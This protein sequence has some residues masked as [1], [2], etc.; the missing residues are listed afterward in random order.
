MSSETSGSSERR[1]T[2]WLG[3]ATLALIT[4]VGAIAQK[5][6]GANAAVAACVYGGGTLVMAWVTAKTT[7]YPRWAWF[8][9][10]AVLVAAIVVAAMRL[11]EPAQVKSWTSTAWM[12]PWLFL[13]SALSPAPATGR[14]SP[15]AAWS[16]PLLVGTSVAFSSILLAAWWMTR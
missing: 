8:A 9:A 3:C 13:V 6:T 5:K 16:G 14:C 15:R 2:M 4:I 11:P 7:A 10:A 12:L 1:R